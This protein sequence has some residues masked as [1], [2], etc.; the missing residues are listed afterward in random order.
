MC[1]GLLIASLALSQSIIIL[2]Y[3][4]KASLALSQSIIATAAALVIVLQLTE[5]CPLSTVPPSSCR[6]LNLLIGVSPPAG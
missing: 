1:R 2:Y 6:L 3:T 4:I 5:A